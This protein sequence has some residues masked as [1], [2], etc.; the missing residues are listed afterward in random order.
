MVLV[1]GHVVHAVLDG[2][3]AEGVHHVV[4]WDVTKSVQVV[5]VTLVTEASS[6][7]GLSILLNVSLGVGQVASSGGVST[8]DR[9]LLEVTL[10]DITSRKRIAAK[11]T[12]VRA[13]AGVSQKVTLKVLRMKVGLCAMGARK[14]S[15]GI[16]DGNDRVLSGT[17]AGSRSGG[18]ARSTRQDTTSALRAH[19]VSRLVTLVLENRVGLHQRA[20]SVGR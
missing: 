13:V 18:S 19:N 20:G 14:L 5:Q 1:S 17:S 2:N 15:I 3:H 16:L 11:D 8:A 4:S 7:L 12:H 10:Q 6:L 9:A